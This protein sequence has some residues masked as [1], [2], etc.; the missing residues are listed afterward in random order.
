[1]LLIWSSSCLPTSSIYILCQIILILPGNKYSNN[2]NLPQIKYNVLGFIKFIF[3]WKKTGN[4]QIHTACEG[5][6]LCGPCGNLMLD[7][8]RWS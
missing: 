5:S 7:D 8:V 3:K 1:M 4:K 2:V 6:R